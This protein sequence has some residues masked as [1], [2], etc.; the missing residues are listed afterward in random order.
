MDSKRENMRVPSF[1]SLVA[2]RFSMRGLLIEGDSSSFMPK[3]PANINTA[4]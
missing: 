3:I 4:S 1:S 2:G